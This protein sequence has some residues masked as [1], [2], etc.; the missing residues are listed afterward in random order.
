MKKVLQRRK[1]I[2]KKISSGLELSKISPPRKWKI[3]LSLENR[4]LG[5]TAS[6]IKKIALA[7]LYEVQDEIT[8][9]DLSEINVV[10]TNDTSIRQIN[11][12]YRSK[13]KAT[14]VLSFPQYTA[15]EIAGEAK[16]KSIGGS[17]LGDLLI[18]SE[19][20]LTQAVKFGVSIEEEFLRLVVHGLLHLIGY[21]HEK[22]SP[23]V[24]ARMRRR[25]RGIRTKLSCALF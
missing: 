15:R 10:I 3:H 2:P 19:T 11:K 1:L 12:K 4:K 25:E 17:Y 6:K 14:D 9:L 7:V 23:A 24:A 13:D 20:T 16:R 5:I 21:D 8:L 22:V 18:S